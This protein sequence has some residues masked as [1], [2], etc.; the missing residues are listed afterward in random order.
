VQANRAKVDIEKVATGEH[1]YG[2]QAL[3]MG[4]VDALRTSDD[5]LSAAAATADIYEISYVRKRPLL[6]KLIHPVV[7]SLSDLR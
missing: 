6:E 2:K 5:Y 7:N 3:E 4:L 1:W